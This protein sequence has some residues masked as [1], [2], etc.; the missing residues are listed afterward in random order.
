M[1]SQPIN[2][3][4]KGCHRDRHILQTIEEWKVLD[5]DQVRCIFF[6]HMAY[7]QRKAQER[8]LKLHRAEK[9]QRGRH[10]DGPYFYYSIDRPGMIKHQIAANW[11]RIWLQNTLSSWEKLHSWNYEQDYKVLRADAFAAIKNTMSGKFRFMFL[12]LDRGTNAFNKV[13]L[14]NRLYDQDKYSS[15]W[16][17]PLADRF[18][19]V[20]VVTVSESRK[21]LI[22][23]EIEAKNISGLE[24]KVVLLEDIR[25]EVMQNAVRL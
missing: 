15:W 2:Q 24:F 8:L 13:E 6:G 11:V 9:L 22:Q 23:S 18:P 19:T 10:S 21:R 1:S 17:V 12:E 3:K 4:Q 16:W 14:Y 5:A 7:G 20:L 25:K